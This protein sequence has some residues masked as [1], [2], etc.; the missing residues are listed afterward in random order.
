MKKRNIFLSFL[1]A[2]LA[3]LTLGVNSTT[4]A[5]THAAGVVTITLDANGGE[6]DFS[7]LQTSESGTLTSIPEATQSNYVFIGWLFNEE[8]VTTET[9][10]TENSTISALFYLKEHYYNISSNGSQFT[11]VGKTLNTDYD[12]TISD[13]CESLESAILLIKSDLNLVSTPTTLNFQNISLTENLMLDFQNLT[14]TGNISLNEFSINYEIPTTKSNFQLKDINLTSTSEQN[15]VNISG[16]NRVIINC[17]NCNFITSSSE[18]NYAL[19]ID[20]SSTSLCFENQLSTQTRFL[21]NHDTGT[22]T[23][24][25]NIDLSSH[26]NGKLAISVPYYEDGAMVLTTNLNIS[27]FEFIPTQSNYT[28]SIVTNGNH[29]HS[30]VEFKIK[31]DENGGIPNNFNSEITLNYNPYN[32]INYPDSNNLSKTHSTLNGF[33]GKITLTNELMALYNIDDAVWYFD[34]ESLNNFFTEDAKYKDIP[35]YFTKTLPLANNNGFTYYSYDSNSEDP[36][37]NAIHLMLDLGL[38]PEFVALWSDT[39]YKINFETNGGSAVS[40]LTGVYNSSISLP[41]TTKTGY[42]FAGWYLSEDL[43]DAS[44]ATS[45]NFNT[46]PD[47]EPTLYAKWTANGHNLII[48]PNNGLSEIT[49]VV[50][51]ESSLSNITELT[52]VNFTKT[53]YSFAGWYTNQSLN[54]DSKITDLETFTMPNEEL[55]IYAKWQINSYTITLNKNHKKDS[56]DFAS[57]TTEYGDDISSLKSSAPSFEGYEFNG[58]MTE[59]KHPYTLPDTMP[60]ENLTLYANWSAI[61]YKIRYI[62]VI[63]PNKIENNPLH[64]TKNYHFEDTII[65]AGVPI[66]SGYIFAGWYTNTSFTEAF[67]LSSMPSHNIEVYAKMV[68]KQTISINTNKQTYS[69]SENYGFKLKMNLSLTNFKVEYLVNDKWQTEIPK[70]KGTYNVRISRVEDYAFNAVNLL[71]EGGLEIVPNTVDLTFYALILYCIAGMEILC[72]I[73]ILL[74]R[75]QRQTY[76]NYAVILPFGLVSTSDFVHFVVSLVLAIFGFVL[77]IIQLT[78][79]K[80]VNNEISKISTESTEYTPPDVSAND[81]IASNVE[82]LLQKEGF[83]K[84]KYQDE[85]IELDGFIEDENE[86]PD[87]DQQNSKDE[88]NEDPHHNKQDDIS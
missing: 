60:A 15:L 6:C 30:N 67:R 48:Y 78:K 61:N 81:S 17:S 68:P 87:L 85:E 47:T 54:D 79:L 46:M 36:N 2:I 35:S 75:K 5:S 9:V 19:Y 71:I 12:Y 16:N 10:F 73:I 28:C 39:I 64:L 45:S 51:F 76:L 86:R 80:N 72:S 43:N 65:D 23:S 84:P 29:L 14:L 31:F 20:N 25:N 63:D 24:T 27:N 3:S 22:S 1:F 77:M 56:S 57:L 38:T 11:V 34:K 18:H 58:W 32:A 33:A 88:I 53:G 62:I 52:E 8:L 83:V 74:L 70:D 13:T 42:T 50:P 82:T 26:I 40:P 7:E 44:L 66:K 4:T 49:K 41:S 59:S 37:F 55:H 69:L 21:Y